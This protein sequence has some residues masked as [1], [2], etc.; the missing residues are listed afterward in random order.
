MTSQIRPVALVRRQLGR[1]GEPDLLRPD[2]ERPGSA[3]DPLGDLA[4]EQV[5]RPD[6]ATNAVAGRS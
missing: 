2:R 1:V 4:T 3:D 6:P 5:R